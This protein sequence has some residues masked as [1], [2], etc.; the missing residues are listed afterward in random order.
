MRVSLFDSFEEKKIQ[1]N[2]HMRDTI[3]K[4]AQ[5][6]EHTQKVGGRR[7]LENH[8]LS[9]LA[10]LLA[11]FL[12]PIDVPDIRLNRTPFND[13]RG[14]LHTSISHDTTESVFGSPCTQSKRNFSRCS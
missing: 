5:D 3:T 2:K 1:T 11:I 10:I 13:R 12:N 6:S 7:R 4:K 8:N 9:S 14:N